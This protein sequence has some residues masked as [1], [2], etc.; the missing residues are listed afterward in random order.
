[1]PGEE[2][3]SAKTVTPDCDRRCVRAIAQHHFFAP[4]QSH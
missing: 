2:F 4:I 3:T 1:M